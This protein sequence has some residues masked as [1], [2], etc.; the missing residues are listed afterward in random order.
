MP[1]KPPAPSGPADYRRWRARVAALVER[2]SLLLGVMRERDWQR[3]YLRGVT[4]EDAVG[5]AQVAYYKTRPAFERRGRSE[6]R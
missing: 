3:L 5:R 2:Q 4:P 1:R 6:D